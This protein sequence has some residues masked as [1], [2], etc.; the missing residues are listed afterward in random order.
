MITSIFEPVKKLW[1]TFLCA[2]EWSFCHCVIKKDL[3]FLKENWI[4]LLVK[5]LFLIIFSNI[6]LLLYII[7][8]NI[9]VK[10]LLE[11]WAIYIQIEDCIL[12]VNE[13]YFKRKRNSHLTKSLLRNSCPV[14]GKLGNFMD[15]QWLIVLILLKNTKKSANLKKKFS[16]N[17]K[18]N[19]PNKHTT[20]I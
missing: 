6:L 17:L 1:N 11:F 5:F 13:F 12:L 16:I 20:T 9:K 10:V 3:K 19:S 15:C 4:F 8:L 14:K 7:V 2:T 18:L